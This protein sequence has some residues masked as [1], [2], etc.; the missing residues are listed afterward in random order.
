MPSLSVGNSNSENG[1]KLCINTNNLNMTNTTDNIKI[2]QIVNLRTKKMSSGKI[3]KLQ[4][5][6]KTILNANQIV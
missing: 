4:K 3:L 5:D 6:T 1:E 2:N